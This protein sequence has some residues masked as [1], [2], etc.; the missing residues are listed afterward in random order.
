MDVYSEVSGATSLERF[1]YV[2]R[3]LRWCKGGV[4]HTWQTR[5][6][7]F[8]GRLVMQPP[9]LLNSAL[10]LC[11]G[12]TFSVRSVNFLSLSPHYEDPAAKMLAAS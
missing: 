1:S 5:V 6:R 3:S 4:E 9:L 10:K 2:R 11:A 12:G 8:P 7:S